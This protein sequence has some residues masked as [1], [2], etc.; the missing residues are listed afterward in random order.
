[1]VARKINELQY[2]A[3]AE[4]YLKTGFLKW[5]P[6]YDSAASEYGKAGTCDYSPVTPMAI[7]EWADN[8][9]SA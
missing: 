2:H 6:D 3:K 1:M 7:L 5:K 4:K 8:F 9:L